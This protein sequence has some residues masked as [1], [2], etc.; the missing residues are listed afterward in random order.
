MAGERQHLPPERLLQWSSG[1]VERLIG[2]AGGRRIRV[3]FVPRGGFVPAY[4]LAAALCDRTELVPPQPLVDLA[5][6]V[7]D[8]CL[9]IADDV[10]DSGATLRRV[11]NALGD[12][13][14][15]WAFVAPVLKGCWEKEEGLLLCGEEARFPRDV[16]VVFPWEENWCG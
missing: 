8:D 4:I 2:L 3:L 16:W 15:R 5:L 6:P 11:Q 12:K 7:D 14:C 1:I 10:V 13:A 9:V